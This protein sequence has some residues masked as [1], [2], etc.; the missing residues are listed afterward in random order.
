MAQDTKTEMV[1]LR[2]DWAQ[3]HAVE[4]EQCSIFA[5]DVGESIAKAM[6]D[7]AADL[8]AALA[9][10]PSADPAEG[11]GDEVERIRR[12]DCEAQYKAA[13]SIASNIGMMLVSEAEHP[14][15]PHVPGTD[16]AIAKLAAELA[17]R[18]ADIAKVVKALAYA[19]DLL[20]ER[21]YGS[22]ARSP[23]HNARLA[24]ERALAA[25]RSS[26]AEGH[27]DER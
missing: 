4:S 19:C 1:L 7:A 3:K 9:A 6:T 26:P 10:R 24:V 21:K 8:R 5:A 14:D 12:W 11:V 13:A 23:G 2:R 17:A 25:L 15:S 22:A 18:D 20:T 16:P 27:V